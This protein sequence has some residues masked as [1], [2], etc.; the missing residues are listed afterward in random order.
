M[1]TLI[2]NNGQFNR[3]DT[4]LPFLQSNVGEYPL[5][6]VDCIT[7]YKGTVDEFIS[8]VCKYLSS[9]AP[10]YDVTYN[11][12]QNSSTEGDSVTYLVIQIHVSN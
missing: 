3:P 12:T 11:I 8:D 9:V 2:Y 10:E 6:R 5:L 4:L 1:F 7:P